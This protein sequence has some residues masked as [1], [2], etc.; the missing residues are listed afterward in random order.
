MYIVYYV[1]GSFIYL[2]LWVLYTIFKLGSIE[3]TPNSLVEVAIQSAI[4]GLSFFLADYLISK[5]K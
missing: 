5:R 2:V 4:A 3:L 1:L